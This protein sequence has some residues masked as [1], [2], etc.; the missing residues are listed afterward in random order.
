MAKSKLARRYRVRTRKGVSGIVRAG[1]RSRCRHARTS[2]AWA[3]RCWAPVLARNLSAHSRKHVRCPIHEHAQLGSE[4]AV[5]W[6]YQV[7][8][9]RAGLPVLE[10]ADQFAAIDM[11]PRHEV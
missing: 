8:G 7:D 5:V 4:V 10:H 11:W 9:L 2:T 1:R 6:I 3:K